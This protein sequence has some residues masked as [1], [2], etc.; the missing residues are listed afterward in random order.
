MVGNKKKTQKKQPYID[1][2]IICS[3]NYSTFDYFNN[4]KQTQQH[5][6]RK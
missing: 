4:Y 6:T 3:T 1:I 5:I 2:Q